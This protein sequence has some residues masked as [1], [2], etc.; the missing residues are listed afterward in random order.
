MINMVH[1]LFNK[2]IVNKNIFVLVLGVVSENYIERWRT[3]Q[4]STNSEYY[5]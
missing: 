4:S 2:I 5:C 1:F 3:A